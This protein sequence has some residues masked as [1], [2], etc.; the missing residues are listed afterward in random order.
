MSR[1][2][3]LRPYRHLKVVVGAVVVVAAVVALEVPVEVAGDQVDEAEEVVG[4]V[5]AV[6]EADDHEWMIEHSLSS[7]KPSK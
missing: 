2:L 4:G 6:E 7:P 3:A 5:V 1:N